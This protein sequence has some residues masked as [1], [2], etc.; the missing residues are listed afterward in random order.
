MK[1]NWMIIANKNLNA[2][3]EVCEFFVLHNPFGSDKFHSRHHLDK[4]IS[5]TQWLQL[6][7]RHLSKLIQIQSNPWKD[8]VS[9]CIRYFHVFLLNQS[10][11]RHVTLLLRYPLHA[12]FWGTAGKPFCFISWFLHITFGLFIGSEIYLTPECN[13]FVFWNCIGYNKRI[14]WWID[15]L[16]RNNTKFLYKSLRK[17]YQ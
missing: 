8:R 3:L 15:I 5:T 6:L 17:I 12:R 4:Y 9:I 2:N 14:F 13:I 1:R 7:L 11:S 10:A 16:K